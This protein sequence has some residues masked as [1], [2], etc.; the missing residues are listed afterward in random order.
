MSTKKKH[1]VLAADIG[2][3]KTNL[4]LFIKG[5]TRPL[6]TALKS[7]ANR[8]ASG[9]ASLIADF[10]AEHPADIRGAC[11]GVAGPVEDGCCRITNLPW[12]I[13]E[14]DI[15]RQFQWSHV[16]LINDLAA[17]AAAIPFLSRRERYTL[18]RARAQRNQNIALVA[19]GTGLGM[20]LLLRQPKGYRW[21]ASEGGH[22]DFAPADQEQTRLWQYLHR[23]FGHVSIERVLSGPGLFNIYK[24]LRDFEN[25]PEPPRLAAQ[26]RKHDPAPLI[27][28]AAFDEKEPLCLKSLHIFASICGAV[29][30]NLALT[31]L[32]TGGIYLGGGMAPKIFPK[33]KTQDFMKSFVS[34][35]RFRNLLEKISV[36]VILNDKAAL[37]GA[38]AVA[39][40]MA[41]GK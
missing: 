40:K 35:G 41:P 30:G 29:A 32:T 17:T 21:V 31:G 1:S 23:R 27:T 39:L 3:T 37:L 33:M 6:P 13:R 19:P 25:Y 15:Q 22:A 12:R 20:A 24:W 9:I 5:K 8:S 34:K 28:A 36:S 7:Y 26:I 4:G 2:G 11:L 38:A 16:S 18:N 10:I 14:K